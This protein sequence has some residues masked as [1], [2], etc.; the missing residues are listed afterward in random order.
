ME[1]IE[2]RKR[3]MPD[4][5]QPSIEAALSRIQGDTGSNST[6]ILLRDLEQKMNLPNT[7]WNTLF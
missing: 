4:S 1:Q 2:S 6:E 7:Y 5:M 3:S